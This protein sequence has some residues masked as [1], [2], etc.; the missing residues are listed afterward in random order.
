MRVVE[1]NIIHTIRTFD[2]WGTSENMTKNLSCRDVVHSVNRKAQVRLWENPIFAMDFDNKSV[3]WFS[4]CNW[5]SITTKSRLNA[6]VP[7]FAMGYFFQKDWEIYYES[8]N[9]KAVKIDTSKIYKIV[10]GQVS[11]VSDFWEFN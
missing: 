3:V 6:L 10:N 1:K 9:Q 2:D 5:S 7:A 8:I 11:E 4:F